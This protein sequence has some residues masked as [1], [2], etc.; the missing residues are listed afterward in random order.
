MRF[1]FLQDTIDSES[2]GLSYISAVLKKA[3]HTTELYIASLENNLFEKINDYSPDIILFSVIITKQDFYNRLGI[4]LKRKFPDIKIIIGGPYV[5][6]KNAYAKNDWVDFAIIGEGEDAIIDLIE[7]LENGKDFRKIKNLVYREGDKLIVNELRDLKEDLDS[8]PIPDRELY[9]KYRSFKDLTVKRFISGRGC[10]YSCTFCF[11]RRLRDMYHQ[12]GKYV[13]K[14]SVERV[15]EEINIMREKS[16][17]NTVHFSD[18]IFLTDKRWL[19]R[20]AKL[21]PEE[22]GL[23]FQCNLT[24]K[25]IDE[26]TIRLLKGCGLRGVGI[27]LESGVE[28]IRNNILGKRFSNEEIEEVSRILHKY[29]IEIYT[30]NMIAL[31]EESIEDAISTLELNRH[32]KIKITQCNIAIPFEGL[33]LTDMA[34][35]NSLL[36]DTSVVFNMNKRPESPIIKVEVKEEFE[37]LFL[38]FPFLVKAKISTK[39]IRMLLK[40]PLNFIYRMLHKISYILNMKRYY[41]ISLISGLR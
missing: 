29:K 19:E 1:L 34:I 21:Y 24:A 14:H 16:V 22:V 41:D 8:L 27:G 3:G 13:R 9:L 28:R 6:L 7:A 2:I 31:P 20:F 12:K 17:L 4:I 25:T 40:L 32:M 33:P 26:E 10:P 11:A 18:D 38:L 5:T 30:Y 23:P 36:E 37:R 15:C 35:Q 39:I